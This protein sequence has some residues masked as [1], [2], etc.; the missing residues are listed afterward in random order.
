MELKAVEL[1]LR[2][3]AYF[4]LI[5]TILVILWGAWVRISHSGDGCGDTWPLCNGKLVPE[6]ARGKTWVEYGHRFTSGLYGLVVIG[7][8]L[9][10]RKLSK[11]LSGLESAY[12]WMTWTLVFMISEAALGAKL[13]LFGL[14]N[15][16][17]SI[18]RLVVMSLHQVNSFMLVAFTV[19]FLGATYESYYKET[20]RNQAPQLT[21][22]FFSKS[23]FL[24]CFLVIAVTGA[25]AS[26]STTLF[27]STSLLDG[28]MKDMESSSHLVLKI[29]GLHPL[30]AL[31]IGGSL[32]FGLYKM[33]SQLNTFLSKIS[34][35]A[36]GLIALGIVVGLMT[37]FLLSPVPLKLI[38]LLLA[39]SL[40][41]TSVFFYH[42][43]SQAKQG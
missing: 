11:R 35:L 19:R 40:W 15:T 8:F 21:P 18:W 3:W 28:L 31:L 36:S 23:S 12:R 7:I 9:W 38:H 14:V 34:M 30:F 39:H 41:S 27:P 13:V 29:R 33:S 17:Q 1:R 2:R 37:L 42:F 4:L 25:W 16:D 20:Y 24:I 26:L 5:Y 43:Y 32:S 10:V 6:A 22:D